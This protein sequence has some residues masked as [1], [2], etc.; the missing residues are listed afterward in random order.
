MPGGVPKL[1]MLGRACA[2]VMAPSVDTR[3]KACRAAA[4][5]VWYLTARDCASIAGSY[6]K[7]PVVFSVWTGLRRENTRVAQAGIKEF[8]AF[9]TSAIAPQ[10]VR[11]LLQPHGIDIAPSTWS[12][13]SSAI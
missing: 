7:I 11:E 6:S 2:C 12:A 13:L 9:P 4:S 3:T 1:G 10:Q 5:N 8:K